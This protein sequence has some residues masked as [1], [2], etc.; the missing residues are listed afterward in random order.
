MGLRSGETAR[1]EG[2]A[3]ETQQKRKYISSVLRNSCFVNDSI[4]TLN[5]VCLITSPLLHFIWTTSAP[6]M[7]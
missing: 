7:R 6:E 5:S 3:V 1:L 2:W 4:S